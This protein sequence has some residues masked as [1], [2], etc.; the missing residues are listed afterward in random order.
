M[1]CRKDPR[2]SNTSSPSRS[3]P[4]NTIPND[5]VEMETFSQPTNVPSTGAEV[6]PPTNE[7]SP[8]FPSAPLVIT[9][10]SSDYEAPRAFGASGHASRHSLRA[11]RKKP[12]R[13]NGTR[14]RRSP[15]TGC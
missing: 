4:V 7:P 14:A 5:V 12:A 6:F 13:K 2:N 10:A 9:T 1:R 8:P 15:S 11:I 3:F